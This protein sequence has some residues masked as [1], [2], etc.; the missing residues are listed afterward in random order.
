MEKKLKKLEPTW[1]GSKNGEGSD[2]C[3]GGMGNWKEAL[4]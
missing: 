3:Q 4:F 1:V 2:T